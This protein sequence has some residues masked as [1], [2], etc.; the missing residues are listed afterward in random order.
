MTFMFVVTA[1]FSV[2]HTFIAFSNSLV[3][4]TA[5]SATTEFSMGFVD[6]G[7]NIICLKLWGEQVGPFYTALHLFFGMGNVLGPICVD[8]FLTSRTAVLG[9]T[10]LQMLH[11]SIG[12]YLL[13]VAGLFFAAIFAAHIPSK[14]IAQTDSASNAN[15]SKKNLREYVVICLLTV[16][17]CIANGVNFAYTNYLTVFATRSEL[18]L[19]ESAGAKAT[20]LYF[21]SSC[22]MKL[23]TVFCILK[24]SALHL[25]LLDLSLLQIGCVALLL[26]GESS[27]VAF[28]AG[29]ALVGLGVSTLF[30]S[31]AVWLKQWLGEKMSSKVTSAF[32]ISTSLGAQCFKIPLAPIIESMPMSL[33]YSLCLATGTMAL[34]FCAVRL[35]T[36]CGVQQ[37]DGELTTAATKY[38]YHQEQEDEEKTY[39]FRSNNEE[40]G[41]KTRSKKMFV[42]QQ[43]E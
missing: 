26:Q 13:I 17:F 37:P 18:G 31:G 40:S 10:Q 15:E 25:V 23:A 1:C 4:V 6:S 36:T 12:C 19:T 39:L 30:C 8:L 28:F 33:I 20:T 35:L 9:F 43:Q 5:I 42:H 2:F 16:F 27:S 11:L 29:T 34:I 32:I 41:E 3:S 14:D 22:L 24:I 7:C 21:G 38:E